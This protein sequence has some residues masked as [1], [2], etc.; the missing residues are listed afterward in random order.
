MHLG[1]PSATFQHTRLHLRP[2]HLGKPISR[3]HPQQ[4][5]WSIPHNP[6]YTALITADSTSTSNKPPTCVSHLNTLLA[7]SQQQ[8]CL[9]Y[10]WLHLL[11]P[12]TCT[13]P[14]PQHLC[15]QWTSAVVSLQKLATHP[16]G[17]PPQPAGAAGT[18]TACRTQHTDQKCD[19][20]CM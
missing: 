15:S 10:R 8:R 4:P 18:A 3:A 17:A 13:K 20:E 14:P 19:V 6:H 9:A 5:T 2:M 1:K 16:Q 7:N 12:N 11:N